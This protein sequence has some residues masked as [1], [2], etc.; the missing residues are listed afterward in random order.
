MTGR[1]VAMLVATTVG[2]AA[3]GCAAAGCTAT[4]AGQS[5]PRN[6]DSTARSGDLRRAATSA[7]AT[8]PQPTLGDAALVAALKRGGLILYFRHGSTDWH[9]LD[10][11]NIVLSDCSTQRMLADSGRRQMRDVGTAFTQLHVPVGDV[12]GSP[13]CRILESA[14]LAFGHVRPDT[15]LLEVA[16]EPREPKEA[17]VRWLVG[18][19]ATPPAVPPGTNLVLVGHQDNLQLA[20]G[21]MYAGLQLS[22]REAEG[23][24]FEPDGHG[25][26]VL[27][28]RKL[29]QEWMAL[30]SGSSA[31]H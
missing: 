31:P 29:P 14:R 21:E 13:Y 11:K 22:L 1:R 3:A 16:L 26:A 12:R 27:L 9:H 10:A 8:E 30:A 2:C 23:A 18:V 24:V 20:T 6:A 17:H 28:A 5:S 15:Q 19:L 4:A 25:K 7:L